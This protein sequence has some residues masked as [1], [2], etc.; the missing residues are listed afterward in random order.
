MQ[1]NGTLKIEIPMQLLFFTVNC[2]L[3]ELLHAHID[4]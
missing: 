1:C 3:V 2:Q 4:V